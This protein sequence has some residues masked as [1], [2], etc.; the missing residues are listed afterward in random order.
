MEIYLII[1]FGTA[2]GI[3]S[4]SAKLV[5]HQNPLENEELHDFVV[6]E[7]GISEYDRVVVVQNDEVVYEYNFDDL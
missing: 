2:D 7:F 4:S 6:K 1:V 5:T 3:F